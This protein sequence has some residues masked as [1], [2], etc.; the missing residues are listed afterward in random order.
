MS[1]K[2]NYVDVI[3]YI[4]LR[5]TIAM[6]FITLLLLRMFI[7]SNSLY[8]SIVL[9]LSIIIIL[10]L[11]VSNSLIRTLT[12]IMFIII[13]IGAMIILIGYVCAVSPNIITSP[14]FNYFSLFQLLFI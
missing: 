14:S 11:L 4:F 2:M 9:L 7:F 12:I 13:Y 6:F 5:L 8:Y 1:D 3:K 10:Y